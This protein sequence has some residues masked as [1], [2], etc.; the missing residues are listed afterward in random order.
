MRTI[1]V[2]LLL[3]V[4]GL[5]ACG[6][7]SSSTPGPEASP[8]AADAATDAGDSADT[9]TDAGGPTDTVV[10]VEPD[11]VAT[12]GLV[13]PPED[14]VPVEDAQPADPRD[15]SALTEL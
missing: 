6:D 8:D 7:D 1:Q 12:D 4:L 13:A 2:S 11:A 3:V 10:P 9:A 5:A 15:P 14:S